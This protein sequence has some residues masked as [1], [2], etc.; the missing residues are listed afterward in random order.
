MLNPS[1]H[2][3]GVSVRKIFCKWKGVLARVSGLLPIQGEAGATAPSDFFIETERCDSASLSRILQ[4][5][6]DIFIF[7]REGN[8]L[9]FT[10]IYPFRKKIDKGA[11]TLGNLWLVH[12]AHACPSDHKP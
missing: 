1:L 2:N 8:N 6:K 5:G 12:R 9:S 4:S 7:P 11:P 3:S 10:E